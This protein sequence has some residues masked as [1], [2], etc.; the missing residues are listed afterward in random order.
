[1]S[2]TF[3]IR[4]AESR[5][6]SI[7][8]T[9]LRRMIEEMS[10]GGGRR[11]SPNE[12]EWKHLQESIKNEMDNPEHLFLI[13]ERT[14][15]HPEGVGFAEARITNRAIVFE[16]K[17]VLHIHSLYV[18]KIHR[19]EGAGRALLESAIQWGRSKHCEEAELSVLLANP[20]RALY[21][22]LG[23]RPLEVEMLYRL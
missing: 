2:M 20:A 22:E 4:K 18:D 10:A 21:E 19:R 15:S 5:D 11:A 17:R 6:S 13:A 8:V 12:S 3:T 1:M 9:Y 23:F 16:P 14:A 7:I